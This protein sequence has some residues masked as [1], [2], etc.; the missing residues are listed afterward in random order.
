MENI[1]HDIFNTDDQY[2]IISYETNSIVPLM[3]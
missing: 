3:G 2:N 1:T